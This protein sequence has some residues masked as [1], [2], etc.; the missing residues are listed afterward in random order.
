MRLTQPRS[1]YGQVEGVI[2]Q[3]RFALVVHLQIERKGIVGSCETLNLAVWMCA[4]Y[5][6][7]P[8]LLVMSQR[9]LVQPCSKDRT[10]ETR[11]L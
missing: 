8:H 1:A 10:V 3:G 2:Y 4:S 5:F 6:S 7:S 9:L 11:T